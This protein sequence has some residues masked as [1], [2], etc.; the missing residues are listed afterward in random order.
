MTP[1]IYVIL[2]SVKDPYDESFEVVE[3]QGFFAPDSAQN[4]ILGKGDHLERS[5]GSLY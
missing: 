2:S 3:S 4:D 1:K 5:E